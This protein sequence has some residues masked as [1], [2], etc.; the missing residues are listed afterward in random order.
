MG[1]D[2]IL[3]AIPHISHIIKLLAMYA[4]EMISFLLKIKRNIKERH[5]NGTL[6]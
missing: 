6:I 5:Q 2:V 3:L 1:S 4:H